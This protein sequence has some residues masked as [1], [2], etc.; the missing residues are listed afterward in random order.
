M[1]KVLNERDAALPNGCS[2]AVIVVHCDKR[3]SR[4]ARWQMGAPL[5]PCLTLARAQIENSQRPVRA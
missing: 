3:N 4:I 1:E 2:H 5:F